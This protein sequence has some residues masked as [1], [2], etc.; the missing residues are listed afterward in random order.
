MINII[1][2]TR[3]AAKMSYGL[4]NGSEEQRSLKDMQMLYILQWIFVYKHKRID[5]MIFTS[6]SDYSR[7]HKFSLYL[8]KHVK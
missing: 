5:H 1:M 4:A 8:R 2:L 6:K 7:I 3:V